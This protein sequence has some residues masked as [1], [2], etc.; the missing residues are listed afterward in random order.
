MRHDAEPGCEIT[1]TLKGAAVADG[2]N[3]SAGNHGADAGNGLQAPA[4]RIGLGG[5]LDLLSQSLDAAIQLTP[6]LAQL[7]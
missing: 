7:G 4:G 1:P 6:F 5:R 2:G 3:E